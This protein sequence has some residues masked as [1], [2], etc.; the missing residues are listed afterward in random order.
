MNEVTNSCQKSIFIGVPHDAEWRL[1]DVVSY[2]ASVTKKY[3]RRIVLLRETHQELSILP[4]KVA[5][6]SLVSGPPDGF[7]NMRRSLLR[8]EVPGLQRV[9]F[10][11]DPARLDEAILEYCDAV[12]IALR[13]ASTE[14]VPTRFSCTL[15]TSVF[16]S[17]QFLSGFLENSRKLIGYGKMVEHV[18]LVSKLSDFEINLFDDVLERDDQS[19][20]IWNRTD[21]GLYECWCIGIRLSR[22]DYVSNAN[23]DDLRDPE[24]VLTLVQDLEAHPD[25]LVAAT[26]INPFYEY[27]PDGHLPADRAGWY[28][29]RAGRFGFFDLAVLLDGEPPQL[30]SH[31]IPHCMPVWRRS[32][33]DRF[34]WFDEARYGTYADWAFW[35]K[36][37]EGGRSGWLN[38]RPLSFYYVN[39]TSHNRRGNDLDRLHK[40]V[41]SDFLE[42]FLARGKGDAARSTRRTPDVPR[43]LNLTG[44]SQEF[45]QHRNSFNALIHALDPLDRQDGLGVRFIPFLERYF[46]WGTDPGEAC[47]THPAPLTEDW[48]GILHV[49]FDAP[50]WYGPEVSPE[51]FFNTDLWRRSRPHCR[52]IITLCA[53]LERDLNVVEP[54]TPT[55]AVL[56][57]TELNTRMF[58]IEAYKSRPRVVQ[59]G[60]WLRKLQ[61]IHK[62]RAVGHE[63]VMLMKSQ[64]QSYLDAEIAQFGQYLDPRVDMRH[65]VPNDEYD[66][67]LSS[68][69][70]LCLL[71]ATAA[72]NVVV[73]CLARA[74]PLLINPLPAVVEYLGRHYPLY[75]GNEAEA[76]HLLSQPGLI[77]AA[78]DY[79]LQRRHEIDLTYA[80]FCRDIAA[81]EM[82]Q[83]L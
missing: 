78:H 15:V 22:T 9:V 3:T 83:K 67:L 38:S 49:P 75:A 52:G 62:L 36:C 45:G 68:S 48:I 11:S 27:P 28:S 30:A 59:V 72:N 60:D 66:A 65:M 42:P 50:S 34:G 80:G 18:F 29:D 31:N 41:E 19:I 33:H 44:R 8:G 37:L 6:F 76:D 21:P 71:Y 58:D 5:S 46:V 81:S 10:I 51:R 79:L 24:H 2:I 55:L 1:G 26:A 39:P 70:V 47:S 54:D 4:E 12:Y 82:Y 20:L 13:S 64:T 32:L 23:V 17:D 35:L 40:V 73:E 74:T 77:V 63:R 14:A 69:V 16:K 7:V 43:K 53:D 56:H 61:A 57:P 25:C